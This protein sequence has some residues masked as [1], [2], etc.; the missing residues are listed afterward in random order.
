MQQEMLHRMSWARHRFREV[1]QGKANKDFYR[2]NLETNFGALHI[3][4]ISANIKYAF[5][6]PQKRIL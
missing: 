2:M 4:G 6:W 3:T 5:A 1:P